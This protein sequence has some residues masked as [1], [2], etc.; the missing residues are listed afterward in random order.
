MRLHKKN[1]FIIISSFIIASFFLFN[2]NIKSQISY[3]TDT[4]KD[5][6]DNQIDESLKECKWCLDSLEPEKPL[7]I[8]S[9][10][11]YNIPLPSNMK[12][13]SEVIGK[14]KNIPL[15]F[16]YNDLNWTRPVYK[17]YWHT[18]PSGNG[19]RWS[20]VPERI[21]YALH[22]IFTTYPTASIYYDFVHNLGISDESDKFDFDYAN[23][24]QVVLV[25]M[26]SNVKKIVT[27]DNQVIVIVEPKRNGLQTLVI[28]KNTVQ[29]SSK[30]E[31]TIFQMVTPE[32]YEIDYSLINLK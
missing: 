20:Y 17:T 2:S 11:I 4:F 5:N 19:G 13:I 12:P 1:I 29:P 10:P 23:I 27:L 6:P 21:N 14:G 16:A 31:A 32:G 28:P 25:A 3:G 24:D 15:Q 18:G 22:R 30:D 9:T 26:Q 7:D 8:D